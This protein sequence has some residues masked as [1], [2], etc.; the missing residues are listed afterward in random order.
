MT[1]ESLDP[2]MRLW[3]TSEAMES[4]RRIH[5]G[6]EPLDGVLARVAG[7]A[8]SAVLDADAVTV[9]VLSADGG[10]RTAAYT[11]EQML[12]VDAQQYSSGRGPCLDAARQR[13]P[14]RVVIDTDEQRWPEYVAAARAQGVRSSLSA[15]LIAGEV[16]ADGELVG[17]LNVYS[18]TRSAFDSFDE[19]LMRLFTVAASM[20]ITN[21]RAWEQAR[22]TVS[23][24]ERAL[25]SRSEIDQAKGVLR[26][27][28]DVDADQAFAILAKQ[29][30]NDNVKLRDVA[31]NILD[32]LHRIDD[33]APSAA[34]RVDTIID[35]D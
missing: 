24:L 34:T 3:T 25:T 18:Q 27:L 26:L 12:A 19:E 16:G 28:Y 2:L 21:A 15:P 10:A 35:S 5:G 9:T 17:S 1:A 30:Q 13:T 22:D 23:Q 20:A 7:T 33:G 8:L 31:R 29:S 32:A 14:V 6:E 4:L 11:D